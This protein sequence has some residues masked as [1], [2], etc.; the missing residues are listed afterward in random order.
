MKADGT[1]V[2]C[3]STLRKDNT[4]KIDRNILKEGRHRKKFEKE[5]RPAQL[6][7]N[8]GR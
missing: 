7:L 2:D 3:L 8:L 1:V 6:D 5:R 4:G